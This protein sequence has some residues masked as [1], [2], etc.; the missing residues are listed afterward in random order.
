[1]GLRD[2]ANELRSVVGFGPDEETPFA[3]RRHFARCDFI[4]RDV[5]IRS[6][7]IH[8]VLHLKD[9]SCHGAA[10]ISDTPF[11]VGATVF[12][13]LQK[14]RFF[15]AEVRWVR[16]FMIGLQFY[17]RLEPEL[18][19]RLHTAHLASRNE[20]AHEEAAMWAAFA[21]DEPARSKS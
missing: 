18:V 20:R 2:W 15:A 12:V 10:G 6:R 4:G 19:E 16:N 14:P 21:L 17:R 8:A 5:A 9:V 1:M 3:D 7:K 11:A 13:Q